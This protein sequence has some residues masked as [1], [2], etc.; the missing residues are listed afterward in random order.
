MIL[1]LRPQFRGLSLHRMCQ[2][3]GIPRSA[4][5]RVEMPKTWQEEAIAAI[6]KLVMTFTGYGYRRIHLSLKDHGFELGQ[7]RVR[8]LMRENGLMAIK[9]RRLVGTTKRSAKS[10]TYP[11]LCKGYKPTS[12]NELWV[13][14]MTAIR[15]KGGGMYLASILDVH[16]RK[17]VA[18]HLS[19]LADTE[20]VLTCLEKALEKRRPKDG[21]IHHS[22]QGSTYTSAA[23]VQ[24]VRQAGGRL[25]YS[26]AGRPQENAYA[27]SF[28]KT[29]KA[30]E[31]HLSEYRSFLELQTSLESYIDGIY[32]AS[33]MHSSLGYRSPDQ[34]EAQFPQ[35]GR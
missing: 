13:T 22:D 20:L 33:R 32:N 26:S 23:Y 28:F 19:R 24:R 21:W 7:R 10:G 14:D 17:V 27:E 15:T 2:L 4:L 30:E 16:S 3:A 12:P 29:L 35:E 31:V 8:R 18:W 1:I 34:F 11:N 9:P 5:Y 25:S 6:Q